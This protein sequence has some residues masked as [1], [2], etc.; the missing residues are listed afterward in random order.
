[1]DKHLAVEDLT[2]VVE[3]LEKIDHSVDSEDD[4]KQS[5]ISCTT[6]IVRLI[7]EIR[8]I[9]SPSDTILN[10]IVLKLKTSHLRILW[11]MTPI[12]ISTESVQSASSAGRRQRLSASVPGTDN[13]NVGVSSCNGTQKAKHLLSMVMDSITL[14]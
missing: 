10:L 14:L 9:I 7:I 6:R 12:L 3:K 8:C 11:D 5:Q 4:V 13:R 2:P 1:M